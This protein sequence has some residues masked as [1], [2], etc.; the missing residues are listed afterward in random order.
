MKHRSRLVLFLS[1]TGCAP[2]LTLSEAD[3]L[4]SLA[5]DRG[6]L[7]VSPTNAYADDPQ[8]AALGRLLFFDPR[9]SSDLDVACA[10][11]HDPDQGFSDDDPV[12]TGVL[13]RRGDRHSMPVTHVA[14]QR[15]FL[16]DGRADSL[17]SQPLK[18]L[19]NESEMNAT[20]L[21]VAHFVARNYGESYEAVF[22]PL[23]DLAVYPAEG[24]PG[25]QA[26]EGLELASKTDVNRVFANV[27]K[28]LASYERK[29]WCADTRFDRWAVGQLELTMQER[30]G[31]ADF[32]RQGCIECHDGPAFSDGEFHNIGVGSGLP[33]PDR[34]RADALAK[35]RTDPFNGAGVFSD[36]PGF[37][38]AKLDSIEGEPGQ[39]GAFK[40]PS[41]RG[42]GQRGA[43]GHRGH[44]DQLERFLELYDDPSLEEGAVGV[45][46]P[47]AE[48][49]ELNDTESM[50]AFLRTLNCPPVSAELLNPFGAMP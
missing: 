42:V 40:T 44:I 14:M 28:A 1:L 25:D 23:P 43:F 27:G 33:E 12:S 39:L 20:R 35:L 47:L 48:A 34:G 3:R 9:M 32:L 2:D 26:W 41:L 31:A 17:W 4:R 13:G 8:A 50:A 38:Q 11:C 30:A 46:D 15:F 16:W 29:L 22:G 45:I 18:A 36:D 37:G 49:V 10:D 24:K 5:A 6:Q 7:P 19:E 21:G